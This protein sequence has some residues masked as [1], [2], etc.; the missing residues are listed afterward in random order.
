MTYIYE[1]NL[2][3]QQIFIKLLNL[4]EYLNEPIDDILIELK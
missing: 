4:F 2:S 1:S 3:A